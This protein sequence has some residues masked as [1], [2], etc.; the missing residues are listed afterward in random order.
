MTD[1]TVGQSDRRTA[2]VGGRRIMMVDRR[3]TLSRPD[4]KM[5]A[6]TSRAARAA[7]LPVAPGPDDSDRVCAVSGS[8]ELDGPRHRV[9]HCKFAE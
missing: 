3:S 5:K 9:L 4:S 2:R 7:G 1:R 6:A 8:V